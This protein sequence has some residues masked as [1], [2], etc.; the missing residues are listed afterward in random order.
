MTSLK[1]SQTT[2]LTEQL[3]ALT[4]LK[5]WILKGPEEILF[6]WRIHW[7]EGRKGRKSSKLKPRK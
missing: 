3:S 5:S 6:I 2:Y 7:A 1:S 4:R